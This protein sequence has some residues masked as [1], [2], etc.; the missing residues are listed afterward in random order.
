[1]PASR[2]VVSDEE[3][4]G[5]TS[6]GAALSKLWP[7]LLLFRSS[8]TST[9]LAVFFWRTL[10]VAASLWQL[11]NSQVGPLGYPLQ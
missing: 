2:A 3:V 5:A 1:M 7:W 11:A 4:W 6:R 8:V 9:F 10:T